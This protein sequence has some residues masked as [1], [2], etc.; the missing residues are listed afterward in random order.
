MCLARPKCQLHRIQ[1]KTHLAPISSPS[2]AGGGGGGVLLFGWHVVAIAGTE[3][4]M[5]GLGLKP[6]MNQRR[7]FET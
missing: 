1:I 2:L 7:R 4:W 6:V 3:E 5:G